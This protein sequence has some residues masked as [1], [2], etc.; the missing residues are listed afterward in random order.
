[1]DCAYGAAV[2]LTRPP[3]PSPPISRPPTLSITRTPPPTTNPLTPHPRPNI[4]SPLSHSYTLVSLNN[5]PIPPS[6][7]ST[8]SPSSPS[9][10]LTHDPLTPV[11]PNNANLPFTVHTDPFPIHS[12][13]HH[14]KLQSLPKVKLH[15]SQIALQ[16]Q[17]QL[18]SQ[19]LLQE[20]LQL[21]SHVQ[22][23]PVL[24]S[25]LQVQSQWWEGP[26]IKNKWAVWKV[27]C[28]IR[29]SKM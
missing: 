23:Q 26:Q 22:L 19:E 4:H 14:L 11:P 24:Q 27:A 13:P 5:A 16:L 9:P 1:M 10:L 7:S 3:T 15:Q 21:Q 18:R 25:Q 2:L 29:V 8:L 20:Q 28:K 12:D 17:L 6:P